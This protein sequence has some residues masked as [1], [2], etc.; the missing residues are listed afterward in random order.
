MPRIFVDIDLLVDMAKRYDLV[1]RVLSNYACERLF[2]VSTQ[3]I[4]EVFMLN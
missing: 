4:R 3:V 1:T 2:G